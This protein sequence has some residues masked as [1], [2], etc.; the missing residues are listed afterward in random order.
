[1]SQTEDTQLFED[2]NKKVTVFYTLDGEKHERTGFIIELMHPQACQYMNT[3]S[4]PIS[5][6]LNCNTNI[7]AGDWAHCCYQTLYASKITTKEDSLPRDLV[8]RQ[9][10]RRLVR[11]QEM[12][13]KMEA[14]GEEKDVDSD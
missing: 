6:L 5:A 10:V 2:P 8:V 4:V 13:R 11:A 12:H 9:I 3:H 1:M 7:R 14:A